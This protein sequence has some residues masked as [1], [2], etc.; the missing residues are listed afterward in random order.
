MPTTARYRNLDARVKRARHI[1]NI[2]I[3]RALREA[4][5]QLRTGDVVITRSGVKTTVIGFD[6]YGG[7]EL[8]GHDGV[9][10]AHSLEKVE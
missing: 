8:E 4:E 6:K 3:E 7:V 2:G 5:K 9:Y 10:A 1:R